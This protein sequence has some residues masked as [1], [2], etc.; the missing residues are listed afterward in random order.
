MAE[1]RASPVVNPRLLSI[2]KVLQDLQGPMGQ[3]I[4]GTDVNPFK[5]LPAAQSVENWAYGNSPFSDYP[6]VTNRRLPVV[7]TGRERE[8]G[9]LADTALMAAGIPAASRGVTKGANFLGDVLT[10]IVTRNPEATSVKVLEEAGNLVPL[11][12]I[13]I[14]AKDEQALAMAKYLEER[15]MPAHQIWEKTGIGRLPSGKDYVQEISD[16]RSV[17]DPKALPKIE[18]SEW[19]AEFRRL[20]D[21]R[22]RDMGYDPEQV[23][24]IEPSHY[25]RAEDYA[26]SQIGSVPT[27]PLSAVYRNPDLNAASFNPIAPLRIG[28]ETRTNQGVRGSYIPD[29]LTVTVAPEGTP[30]L[31]GNR[32]L[33]SEGEG[34]G[35]EDMRSTVTHELQH[36]YQ[37]DSGHGLGGNPEAA[38]GMLYWASKYDPAFSPAAT[39]AHQEWNQAFQDYNMASKGEYLNQLKDYSQ[40]PGLKPRMIFGK[41]DWYAYGDDY[42]RLAG[43][44]PKKPG[45]ARDQWLNGAANHMLQKNLDKEPWSVGLMEEFDKR[46]AKNT[47]ARASRVMKR[48]D[49]VSREFEEARSKYKNLKSLIEDEKGFMKRGGEYPLYKRLEGEAIARLAQRRMNL[50]EAERRA[51]Y[52]FAEQYE[53]TLYENGQPAKTEIFN[54]YGLD[55]PRNELFTYRENYKK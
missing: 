9:D 49:K 23:S 32:S 42:R 24:G 5:L 28:P 3:I 27:V 43:P 47:Q 48:N 8:V 2:A 36:V 11:N 20:R 37:F 26:K 21:Q 18:G 22:L 39:K 46:T 13:F 4:P 30:F 19:Q 16:A 10:Q 52:P 55:V 51:N 34:F 38:P 15:G 12:R 1:M 6:S 14:P 33:L 41:A 31:K 7:K 44:M 45:P 17:I 53:R 25:A 29:E 54:P 40:R 35:P 50:S